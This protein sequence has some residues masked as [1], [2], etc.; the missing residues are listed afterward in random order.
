MVIGQ[1]SCSK[2][3]ELPARGR[4]R[5]GLRPAILLLDGVDQRGESLNPHLK[6]V[7]GLNWPNAGG[8]T[9]EDDVA[10]KQRHVRGNEAD[11]LETIE[12]KLIRIGILA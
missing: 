7:P 3:E 2:E 10:G 9:S 4:H 8:R 12:D 11:D 1:C 5:Q 6:L